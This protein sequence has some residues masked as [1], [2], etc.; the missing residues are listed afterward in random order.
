MQNVW[1][2]LRTLA[3]VRIIWNRPHPDI[4]AATD[5]KQI[6][7]DPELTLVERRCFL[8]HEAFHIRYGHDGCQPPAVE[9]QIRLEVSEFLVSIDDLQRVAGWTTSPCEIADELD[10]T[11]QIVIDRIDG[12]SD[13]QKQALWP[14]RDHIP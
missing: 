7:I 11:E 10:V 4:V 12:L 1:G 13:E 6:W 9:R 14:A 8:A 5:G 2:M 3:P